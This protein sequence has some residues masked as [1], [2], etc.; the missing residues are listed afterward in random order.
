M[1]NGSVSGAGE[2]QTYLQWNDALASAVFRPDMAGREVLLAVTDDMIEQVGGKGRLREFVAAVEQGPPWADPALGLCKNAKRTLDGWRGRGLQ[3]PPYIGYLALFVLAVG[4]QGDFPGYAYYPRLR[5]LLAWPD[6]NAGTL[7][8][9]EEMYHLWYD[10]E[11]WSHQDK[12]GELGLFS[13]RFAGEWVHVGLPKAQAVLTEGERKDLPAIFAAAALDPTAPPSDRELA[14]ELRHYGGHSL[15]SRTLELLGDYSSDRELTSL[16]LDAVRTELEDWNGETAVGTDAADKYSVSATA[17]LC[18]RV[19]ELSGRAQSTLR[20]RAKAEFPEDGLVLVSDPEGVTLT[21]RESELAG[22][23]S[24]LQDK[25]TARHADAST[26]DWSQS[27][28]FADRDAGWRVRLPASR[29]RIFVP[30]LPMGLPGLVEFHDIERKKP[31]YLAASPAAVPHL[32]AWSNSGEVDLQTVHIEGLPA[33]WRFFKSPLGA[34]GDK[35]I[36]KALPELALPTT[37][38][39]RL[40]GG[41]RSERGNTYF[42]FAPPRVTVEGKSESDELVCQGRR[43][44]P[45]TEGGDIFELPADLPAGARI[46]I[47]VHR[48]GDV[49]RRQSLFLAD[50]FDWNLVTP[51]FASNS[52]GEVHEGQPAAGEVA[53]ALGGADQPRPFPIR[54]RVS[55]HRRRFIVGRRP[56]EIKKFFGQPPTVDWQPVWLVEIRRRG[57]AEY[58]GLELGGSHPDGEPTGSRRERALWKK[59]LWYRRKRIEPPQH[60]K[61]RKLW[62]DFQEVASDVRTR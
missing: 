52:L 21:C 15:R 29:V 59:V 8:S 31:F 48:N 10:L 36:R 12:G 39:L 56:G 57:R 25:A 3:F 4:V 60:P 51:M 14:R 9:F 43:L 18:L 34:S 13:V 7:P 16:L 23:S 62:S 24:P 5:T 1:S 35:A 22:W 54:P 20:V 6:I 42:S 40:T 41:V 45:A 47:E 30:G 2:A 53:G 11:V 27:H 44:K 38:R 26:F 33:G 61:L 28:L 17:R 32:D 49:V 19:D 55:S 50:H 58:C 37:V 46:S